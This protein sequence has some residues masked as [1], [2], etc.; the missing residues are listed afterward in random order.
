MI[1]AWLTAHTQAGEQALRRLILQPFVSALSIAVIGIAIML[2]L[3]LYVVFENVKAA[4]ARLNTEPNINVYLRIGARDQE[5]RDVENRLKA[6][7]NTA[8]IKFVSRESA[9]AEMKQISSVA[10]LL[11]GLDGNPLPHAF[12]IRPKSS[13]PIVLA[14][15]RTEISAISVVETVVMDFEWAQK[16]KRLT[17]FAERVVGVLTFILALA[18][19][20]ITG[21]TARLQMLTQKDEIE[22][23]RLIGATNRFIRRPFLYFGAV[24]GLLAG[25][26]SISV[27]FLLVWLARRELLALTTS[28]A[29]DFS[30][31]FIS[32]QEVVSALLASMTLGWIGAYASVSLYLRVSL[33]R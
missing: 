27:L 13:D 28:Y 23:S 9:L 8:D 16:L 21:N 22:V 15:M 26:L 24:Q 33:N 5:T 31:N 4:T 25:S 18:V 11:A 14:G 10:G 7:A 17:N 19:V 1:S 2:P 12:A 3:G 29:Y 20:F 6:L 30:I 32:S